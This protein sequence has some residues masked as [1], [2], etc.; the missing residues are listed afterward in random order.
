MTNRVELVI[1]GA[2]A[3]TFTADV[4]ALKYAQDYY[5]LDE[6]V[7]HALQGVG[8]LIGSIQPRV[9]KFA[10]VDARGCIS[11]KHVLFVG[12]PP[13]SRFAYHE[14]RQFAGQALRF[15][16]AEAPHTEHVAM[17]IHGPGYGLDEVEACLAQVEGYFDAMR[18]GDIPSAMKRI[19][20]VDRDSG[21][22][23]RL[24]L[25]LAKRL[26]NAPGVTPLVGGSGHV[27]NINPGGAAQGANQVVPEPLEGPTAKPHVFVAMSFSKHL[28]DVFH[29]GIQEP[30]HDAGFLCE[31]MDRVSYTGEVISSLKR[32][33][34][35]AKIVIAELS[36]ANPNVYLEVG[37]AW[38]KARP[39]ILLAPAVEELAFDVKGH[40]CLLYEGI[41][42]LESQLTREL[43]ALKAGNLI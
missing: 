2:D 26:S 3:T 10:Y 21:R 14:I 25:A 30:V 17:T 38:G 6:L 28:D 40:R 1:E 18:T 13:L 24:R 4:L 23:S 35:T 8:V 29:Y 33:I 5:G 43:A 20:I 31:R 16:A 19:T 39:T 36:G 41:R 22:A 27:V 7:A 32:K 37:Y 15:L 42:D 12:V 11:A 9:G 34:E